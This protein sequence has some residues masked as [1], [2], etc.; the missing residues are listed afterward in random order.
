MTRTLLALAFLVSVAHGALAQ[1]GTTIEID[2]PWARASTGKTGV[3]YLTIVNKG[4]ADDRLV[5]ASTPVAEK[6]EPHTTIS[7]NGVM[8]MRPVDGIEDNAGG[9]AELKPGGLHLMLMGL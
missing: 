9:T 2:H 1:T 4:T 8:K 5:S 6:A 3:A 7:D